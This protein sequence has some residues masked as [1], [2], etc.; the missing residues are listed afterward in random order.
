MRLRHV[1]CQQKAFRK[2]LRKA[3]K[4]VV[5]QLPYFGRDENCSDNLSCQK[6]GMN[7]FEISKTRVSVTVSIGVL[8]DF[9]NRLQENYFIVTGFY[10]VGS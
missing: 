6:G 3:L 9:K 10:L 8:A 1:G 4:V 2:P 7:H 5:K